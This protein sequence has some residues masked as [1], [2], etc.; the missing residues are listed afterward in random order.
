MSNCLRPCGLSPA[1]LFCPWD[2]PGKKTGAGYHAPSPGDLPHPG[3]EP[4]SP[5]L[6][7]GSLP[8][9]RLLCGVLQARILERVAMPF[10]QGIFPPPGIQLASPALDGRFSTAESPGKLHQYTRLPLKTSDGLCS[11]EGTRPKHRSNLFTV[12]ENFP[13]EPALWLAQPRIQR[14]EM[15]PTTS[16]LLVCVCGS[17]IC[18]LASAVLRGMIKSDQML[19]SQTE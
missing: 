11:R 12:N 1:S 17:N 15:Q 10:L 2:S 18:L 4:A 13:V 14:C 9:S 5:A 8:L 6:Q 16:T 7:V 3:I 19:Q